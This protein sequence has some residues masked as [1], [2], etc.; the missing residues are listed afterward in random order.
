MR[1]LHF[2]Q[3]LIFGVNS[4][5]KRQKM[6]QNDKKMSAALHISGSVHHT[7]VILGTYV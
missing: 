1:F 7:I 6:A 4:G 3:I 2:F 5:V